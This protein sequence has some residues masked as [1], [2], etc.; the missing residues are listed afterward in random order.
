MNSLQ[1]Y[2]L[3]NQDNAIH[4][5]LHY[6]DIYDLWFKKY[7]NKQIIILE[8]GVYQGGSLKMWREYFGENAK[9]YAIDINPDCK[10]F[11]SPNT[12]IFIGS[13][14]DRDF[15]R[16]VRAQI[17]EIDILVDDGG[18]TMQQQI[19]T[20]EELYPHLKFGGI[21]LCEDLHTSYW[22]IYGGGYQKPGTFIEFSKGLIDSLHAWHSKDPDLKVD[23][24]TSSAYGLHYYDS[25]LV[26]E[27]KKITPPKSEIRGNIII[28]IDNFP[29]PNLPKEK[30]NSFLFSKALQIRNFIKRF[31]FYKK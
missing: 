14:E 27:K 29:P 26:I 10:Q 13:Q 18:H 2:F 1:T 5:W 28:P 23:S 3:N 6:F 24:I 16:E 19:I 8:I 31:S 9:I 15:L 30:K 21:Y 17:P 22:K 12:K 7:K 11:E 25:I 4:K 20:F